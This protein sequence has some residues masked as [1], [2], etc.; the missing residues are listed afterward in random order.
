MLFTFWAQADSGSAL[1]FNG[2][3]SYVSIAH[4]STLNAFPLTITAWVK[5]LRNTN[6]VDGIVSK[7]AD[8]SGNGY[9]LNL[10]NGNLYAWYYRTVG[11]AIT[12]SPFGLDGG[13]IADGHW[14]HIAFVITQTNGTIYVD[15]NVRNFISW[16]GTP[17]APTS[18]EPLL[19]G[20]YDNYGNAFQGEI[21][22]VTL[23]NRALP[24]SEV[25]YLKHRRLSGAEDGLLGYWKFDEGSGTAANNTA[26]NAFNGT[27]QNNPAWVASQAA[28]ALEP[29]AANCLKF[30]GTNG[31]VQVA[32]N[33]DLNAYPL[34]ASAWFRTTNT[35]NVVQGIVS[36]YVDSS[37]NGWTV[38]V[39][40]GRLRGFYLRSF[41][42]IALDVTSTA[43]VADGAW[44]HAAMVVDVSGGKLFLDGTNVGTGTWSGTPG[45]TTSV[46]PLQIGRYYNYAQRFSGTIDEVAV[47]NRALTTNEILL[48]KNLLLAGNE[49]NLVAY[50]RLD[51]GTGTTTADASGLGH[52]GT[53]LSN[54]VWTGST[55]YL[56]DGSIHLI[57]A[58]SIPNFSQ[59]YAIKTAVNNVIPLLSKNAFT[60]T[61]RGFLRRFYDFGSAPASVALVTKLDGTLQTVGSGAPVPVKPNTV[62]NSFS[63]TAYNASSPQPLLFGSVASL[64]STVNLEP[65]GVQLDSI[66]T[67]Y[68]GIETLTHTENGGAVANDGSQITDATRLLHFNGTIYFGPVATTISNIANTPTA[69]TVFAPNYL[70]APIQLAANGGFV[71]A[72]PNVKFGGGAAF[73]VNLGTDGTATN[74]NGSFSL[75]AA[76]QFFEAAGIRYQLPGATL[77]PAGITA[78]S[79]LAWF[80]TGFG[81]TLNTNNRV[82]LP[83]ASKT[84]IVLD[85]NLL[86]TTNNVVFTAASYNTNR[87]YFAEETKPF[88]IGA[89]QI[90]WHVPQGEFYI[91]QAD[92]VTFVREQED[93]DL[94]NVRLSLVEPLAGDRVS[95][96]GYYRHITTKAGTPIYVRPNAN[97]AAWLTMEATLQENEFR[98]HFPY[99]NRN[100]GG[101]IPVVAG[102]FI[103]SNDTVTAAS[104]LLLFGPAPMPYARDCGVDSCSAGAS[105]APQ[106]LNFTAPPGEFG[107][108]QLDFTPEGGLLAYGTIPATNL[109]W[110]FV[111]GTQFAQRT[112]DVSDGAIYF[113]GTFLRAEDFAD[114]QSYQRPL[115]M[116]LTGYGTNNNAAYVERPGQA[117]YADGFANYAGLNFRAPAQG[118][119][120]I[121]GTDTGFY[122]LTSR[123]KYYTRFG[124]VSGIHESASFPA[125]LT[126]YGYAFTFQSY[127]LS[128]LDSENYESRTDGLV[129][130]P[131]P[132][133]F[134]VEFERMKFLCRGNLDS[135]R[136]PANI[137]TKHLVYWNTDLKLLS[138]QFKPSVNNPC[139]VTNRYLV[140]GVETKL[141]FIPQALHAALAIKSNG[142]IAPAS[143]GVEG[144]DSR[145]AVPANLQLQGPGGSFYPITT[146]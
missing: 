144:T 142:N 140:L 70:Q 128:F 135:A 114:D 57:A 66:N 32:H 77:G 98:P 26:T 113:A 129:S 39:Q 88:L 62:T 89:T 45:A 50:W 1:R 104:H 65:D 49:A 13:A 119:S 22:E 95:N 76:G 44:H 121:A 103:V 60:I 71:S 111:S 27:L 67:L 138:L 16:T 69:G 48:Q 12:F 35:N 105:I 9:S 139:S 87:L 31:Y 146:A 68:Q 99:L 145:F 53:L 61:A 40:N 34:T 5:T 131:V 75:S 59:Q 63:M 41:A 18:T 133:G 86:P 74:V 118:R 141:P 97:G 132:S 90:E 21:D 109:T 107:L 43:I 80:P 15:G 46:E 25:N 51:E 3:N 42:S 124:G 83:Y 96:D 115:R 108:G 7:Y 82:M 11:S 54:A 106:I 10:R 33:N 94:A 81:L 4:A 125:N 143:Q 6:L 120:V 116:L 36:K 92:S 136:L 8:A 30:D 93:N 117:N 29:V 55:A 84:N 122:P 28:I 47:W 126:L 78:T 112:S 20:R 56:G 102:T 58:P 101:H 79:L 110:G 2:T 24:A 73:N 134:P 127:R 23:W 91:S 19:I 137:D 130:L 72:Y 38:V 100:I 64:S 14:H 85:G 123:S 52:T 37:G 17:G